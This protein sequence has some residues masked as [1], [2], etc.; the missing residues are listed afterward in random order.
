MLRWLDLMAKVIK[1]KVADGIHK[2]EEL[3]D[4]AVNG[5]API[6]HGGDGSHNE[7]NEERKVDLEKYTNT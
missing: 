3:I 7:S 6:Y 2:A 5:D 1:T 4:K